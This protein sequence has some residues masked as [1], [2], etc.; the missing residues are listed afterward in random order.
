MKGC[1]YLPEDNLPLEQN[2]TVVLVDKKTGIYDEF[3]MIATLFEFDGK[4][5]Y[6]VSID[7]IGISKMLY[8]TCINKLQSICPQLDEDNIIIN[9]THTHSGPMLSNLK[10][11][12]SG[13]EL[14]EEDMRMDLVNGMADRMAELLE[15]CKKNLKPFTSEI[16]IAN[17]EGVYSNRNSLDGECD[18]TTTLLRFKDADTEEIIGMW[19]SFATHPTMIFPKNKKLSS[20]LLGNV[21]HMLTA[22]YGCTVMH[23]NGAA[24][25]SSTRLTRKRGKDPELDHDELLRLSSLCVEQTVNQE[26]F[27]ELNIDRWSVESFS[28]EWKYRLDQKTLQNRVD[29]IKR[30]IEEDPESE[31]A[32]VFVPALWR[33]E[34]LSEQGTK[35]VDQVANCKLINL[36][37]LK[38]CV[39]P[40]E[41]CGKLGKQVIKHEPHNYV[42]VLGYTVNN[43][44]YLIEVEEYG[45]NFETASTTIPK[46]IPEVLTDMF[47]EKLEEI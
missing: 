28:V 3:A 6:W 36:G 21:R 11:N 23:F 40:G 20:D 12:F 32:R 37:E 42:L 27:K 4:L 38:I 47:K 16:S 9:G 25:D 18:K 33:L 41:L 17:T 39:F 31:I 14:A 44:G 30:K 35:S 24:G 45:K 1:Y 7:I 8:K 19:F 46:G 43:I 22:H 2:R 10:A 13:K 29:S 5:S 26:N 15:E 34:L